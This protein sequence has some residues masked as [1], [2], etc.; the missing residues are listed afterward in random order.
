VPLSGEPADV[1]DRIAA[2]SSWLKTTSLPK[3][4]VDAEPG[5][6]ITGGI[7]RLA[8]SFP[9]QHRVVVGGLHFVQEDSPN[10]IARAIADLLESLTD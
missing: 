2:Y 1:H 7:R 4:F 5:V 6:F 9:N 3:L 10:E 8:S